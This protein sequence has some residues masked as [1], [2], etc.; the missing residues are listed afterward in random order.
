MYNEDQNTDIQ[1]NQSKKNIRSDLSEKLIID[2]KNGLKKLDNA[3]LKKDINSLVD[4]KKYFDRVIDTTMGTNRQQ[5]VIFVENIGNIS[6]VL[7]K[8]ESPN[9][10]VIH[11]IDN[12]ENVISITIYLIDLYNLFVDS[13]NKIF[14]F[15]YNY[16]QE[17]QNQNKDLYSENEELSRKNKYL[18]ETKGMDARGFQDEV[19]QHLDAQTQLSN[20]I[21]I[22]LKQTSDR[23]H[24]LLT[25]L[26]SKEGE[27]QELSKEGENQENQELDQDLK[28]SL[29][30]PHKVFT[31]ETKEDGGIKD[32]EIENN[33]DG[34]N[35]K[36][37]KNNE[38]NKESIYN[39]IYPEGYE[40]GDSVN[41]L[42]T[43]ILNHFRS[44]TIV[45]G[46]RLH[47]K[48]TSIGM[49][50]NISK[51]YNVLKFLEWKGAIKKVALNDAKP[52]SG[53][54]IKYIIIN[55]EII[56]TLINNYNNKDKED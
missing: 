55:Q 23:T 41:F 37:D 34:E 12:I 50:I 49:K 22:L 7:R 54:N 51:I 47:N 21:E 5:L 6:K 20:R 15:L 17:L 38:N 1:D 43:I 16:C 36:N 3:I 24:S 4:T 48:F 10:N 28:T 19:K 46:S 42:I 30:I 26:L 31:P 52:I 11:L 27:N 29:V 13:N 2:L 35:N 8:N 25:F 56:D 40:K 18:E 14:G 32:E 44:N 9:S 33:Q 45:N 39:S 53:T